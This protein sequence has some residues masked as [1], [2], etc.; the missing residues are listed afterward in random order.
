MTAFPADSCHL[1][2]CY[3]QFLDPLPRPTVPCI[4]SLIGLQVL[5]NK[6][7]L[8]SISP[9]ISVSL[10]PCYHLP[11]TTACT[12]CFKW[13]P[14]G[15]QPHAMHAVSLLLPP[16]FQPSCFIMSSGQCCYCTSKSN[17]VG[18]GVRKHSII[19]IIVQMTVLQICPF[20]WD[21]YLILWTC[22]V[23]SASFLCCFG[24]HVIVTAIFCFRFWMNSW[25]NIC[26]IDS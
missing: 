11:A 21:R 26:T 6:R 23:S 16:N 2:W 5:W 22:Q 19:C 14:R 8:F 3:L 9:A 13:Y 17:P 7:K 1:S 15:P 24:T 25:V 18:C 12:D 10:D 20:I 4:D